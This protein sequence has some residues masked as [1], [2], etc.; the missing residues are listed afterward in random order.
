MNN[1]MSFIIIHKLSKNNFFY[2]RENKLV[3]KKS[4]RVYI[5]RAVYMIR[6][7]RKHC[8]NLYKNKNRK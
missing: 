1:V 3:G 2:Y 8:C 7:K 6:Q 5:Q 4:T